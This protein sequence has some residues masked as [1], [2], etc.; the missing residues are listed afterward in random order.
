MMSGVALV[1]C[2]SPWTMRKVAA[3]IPTP[4]KTDPAWRKTRPVPRTVKKM[5]NR[6][7]PL[8]I[9]ARTKVRATPAAAIKSFVMGSS[10]CSHVSAGTYR[11]TRM[12]SGPYES[13]LEQQIARATVFQ[14]L[15]RSRKLQSLHLVPAACKQAGQALGQGPED[16]VGDDHGGQLVRDVH[17]QLV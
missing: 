11:L 16:Q 3:M 14:K 13:P 9:L 12:R 17:D 6:T 10:R 15:G 5:A 8:S 2:T 4:A 1:G 7:A